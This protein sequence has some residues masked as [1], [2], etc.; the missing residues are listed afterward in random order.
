MIAVLFFN[1]DMEQ[2]F[3]QMALR[4]SGKVEGVDDT[5]FNSLTANLVAVTNG[6]V[7]VIGYFAIRTTSTS[8]SWSSPETVAPDKPI[9]RSTRWLL[10]CHYLPGTCEAETKP[11]RSRARKSIAST[12]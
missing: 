2:I 5:I 8:I 1:A 9:L 7:I 12:F 11:V 10:G 6:F 3:D 4:L